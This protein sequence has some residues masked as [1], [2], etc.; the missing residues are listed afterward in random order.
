MS[1]NKS[2]G[3]RYAKGKHPMKVEKIEKDEAGNDVVVFDDGYEA[4]L[5]NISGRN[6]HYGRAYA[7]YAENKSKKPTSK[8]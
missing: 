6:T 4:Q 7:E 5:A 1:N 3:K 2:I 8:K